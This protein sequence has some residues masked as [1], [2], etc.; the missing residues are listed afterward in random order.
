M[1]GSLHT[2]I[3]FDLNMNDKPHSERLTSTTASRMQ[4]EAVTCQAHEMASIQ[5]MAVRSCHPNQSQ[6]LFSLFC[7]K[8]VFH[9]PE[10]MYNDILCVVICYCDY[11][12]DAV[13]KEIVSVLVPAL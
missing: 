6:C 13:V 12:T 4:E 5:R 8:R 2:N 1:N 11:L 7:L 10:K 9:Q 3:C